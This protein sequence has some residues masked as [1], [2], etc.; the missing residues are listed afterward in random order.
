MAVRNVILRFRILFQ[1]P[2]VV[3]FGGTSAS[4]RKLPTGYTSD[5]SIA[6]AII[7]KSLGI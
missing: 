6:F 7:K 1:I 4:N 5:W 3:N 2:L